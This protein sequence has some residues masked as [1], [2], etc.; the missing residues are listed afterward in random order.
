MFGLGAWVLSLMPPG[1]SDIDLRAWAFYLS[2]L[3]WSPEAAARCLEVLRVV[4]GATVRG[5]R[6]MAFCNFAGRQR[7]FEDDGLRSEF[8]TASHQY[9]DE[10]VHSLVY[11]VC[12]THPLIR[13]DAVK[14]LLDTGAF[15]VTAEGD[16][17]HIGGPDAQD[18][19][20]MRY[21]LSRAIHL[22][23]AEVVRLLL[24][25]GASAN[26]DPSVPQRP[27]HAAAQWDV[28]DCVEKVA[29]LTA[30]GADLE[31][32]GEDMFTPLLSSLF[33]SA[34]SLVAF[35]ALLAA[36]ADTRCLGELIR[37][38]TPTGDG[39]FVACAALHQ[40]VQR[41]SI[42]GLLRLLDP[43]IVPPGTIDLNVYARDS[44]GGKNGSALD[45]AAICDDY[46]MVRMLLAAVANH[47]AKKPDA[48]GLEL[49]LPSSLIF[50]ASVGSHRCAKLLLQATPSPLPTL[51]AKAAF[52]RYIND[53]ND[54]VEYLAI[55]PGLILN[56]SHQRVKR[57]VDD[58]LKGRAAI[59]QLVQ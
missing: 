23:P 57:T 2:S 18:G 51:K 33:S 45:H 27:L 14:L 59:V 25:A 58:V 48:K 31:A 42:G 52:L 53:M 13:A 1:P 24:A 40:T 16:P 41:G 39:T 4:V 43:S 37:L 6:K 3:N 9:E 56:Q 50:A 10:R 21:V 44:V 34:G 12:F 7:L 20:P 47:L 46:R 55:M 11:A 19:Q 36:G 15:T 49:L 38:P 26:G 28:P 35:D 29:L 54:D 17:F 22:A 30:H 8:P 5:A 32:R